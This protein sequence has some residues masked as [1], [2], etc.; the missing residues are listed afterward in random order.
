M[1]VTTTRWSAELAWRLPS[2][3]SLCRLVL[4]VEAGIGQALSPYDEVVR[5]QGFPPPVEELR[6][7]QGRTMC[8]R[9]TAACN[10]PGLRTVPPGL[11]RSESSRRGMSGGQLEA[12]T[13]AAGPA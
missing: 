9:R 6:A 10:R 3:L 13:A 12:P 4:P 8:R 7:Q 1:H 5:Q 2:R 11:F